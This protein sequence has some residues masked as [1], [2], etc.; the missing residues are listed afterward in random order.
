M[1]IASIGLLCSFH[2]ILKGFRF[3]LITLDEPLL[4]T[5]SKK[6]SNFYYN[7]KVNYFVNIKIP[8]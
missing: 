3:R 6:I 8:I 1:K 2:F 5:N 7:I 4:V